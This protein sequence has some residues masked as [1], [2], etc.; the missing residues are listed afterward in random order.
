MIELNNNNTAVILVALTVV[1]A[2]CT[3]NGG[4][5]DFD[6]TTGIEVQNFEAVPQTV[7]ANQAVDFRL[8]LVNSGEAVAEDVNAD[9][10]N[11]PVADDDEQSWEGDV[12]GDEVFNFGDI[13]PADPD[14]GLEAIPQ[15]Q[16]I[17]L[18]P[19]AGVQRTITPNVIAAINYGYETTASSEMELISQ[20]RFSE[21][22]PEQG[23]PEVDNSAGPVQLDIRTASP[24]IFYEGGSTASGLTVVVENQGDGKVLDDSVMLDWDSPSNIGIETTDGEEGP[25]EVDLI[26]GQGTQRFDID[27]TSPDR[28]VSMDL[29][30]EAEYDYEIETQ[31]SV[32]VQPTQGD[33]DS[34]TED[35]SNGDE[36]VSPP[37]GM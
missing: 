13:Q 37:D 32:T 21:E 25:V 19:P 33:S 31:T 6:Q 35:D 16:S 1:A 29:F 8:N 7:F 26:N 23:E 5:I 36:G 15:E 22:S 2:G 11:I 17:Q 28:R 24:I 27:P 4:D 34:T 12:A 9:L 10:F 20:D 3:D 14:I 30:F 18:D